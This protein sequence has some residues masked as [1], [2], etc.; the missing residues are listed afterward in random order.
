MIVDEEFNLDLFSI[1][2]VNTDTSSIYSNAAADEVFMYLTE[3]LNNS[4]YI[5]SW[6]RLNEC[7]FSNLSK[8]TKDVL[9]VSIAAVTPKHV[10]SSA[11]DVIT[12]RRNRLSA[13]A[14]SDI[15][16]CKGYYKRLDDIILDSED[17]IDKKRQEEDEEYGQ[18]IDRH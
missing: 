14:I 2:I 15:I 13:D 7:K 8:I 3:P 10:F 16:M 12:F 6:W 4:S 5:L 11:R 18:K 9:V 1:D 17:A